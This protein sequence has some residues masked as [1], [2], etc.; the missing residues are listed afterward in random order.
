MGTRFN[1][2]YEA[3]A[4]G[5][6]LEHMAGIEVV[7]EGGVPVALNLFA[8]ELPQHEQALAMMGQWVVASSPCRPCCCGSSL[9][10]TMGRIC[11]WRGVRV[12]NPP[13]AALLLFALWLSMPPAPTWVAGGEYENSFLFLAQEGCLGRARCYYSG[14]MR[15]W[16]TVGCEAAGV[17][18]QQYGRATGLSIQP[19]T[20]LRWLG[21]LMC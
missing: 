20:C 2:R 10:A 13:S 1:C 9:L 21:A 8:S 15:Q 12:A 14:A 7:K 3:K 4:L 5:V 17:V 6:C 18:K 16:V 11:C 19:G